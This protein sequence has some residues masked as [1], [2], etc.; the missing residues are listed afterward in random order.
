MFFSSKSTHSQHTSRLRLV[1]VNARAVIK[2][3][4]CPLV[5]S[6]FGFEKTNDPT[7]KQGRRNIKRVECALDQNSYVYKVCMSLPSLH[8]F[9][10]LT[11]MLIGSGKSY[12]SL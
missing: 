7:S 1:L 12:R 10:S 6:I 8:I 11:H 5:E 2:D 9:I 4:I 3:T